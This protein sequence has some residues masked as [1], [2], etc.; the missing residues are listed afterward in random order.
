MPR[1]AFFALFVA[2]WVVVHGSVRWL[3]YIYYASG[4]CMHSHWGVIG[5]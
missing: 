2:G 4:V 1:V 5:I 3:E